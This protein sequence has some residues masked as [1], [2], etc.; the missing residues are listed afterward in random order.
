MVES[1]INKGTKFTIS[2]PT[3]LFASNVA[4]GDIEDYNI[5]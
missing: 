2:F 4:E 5:T 1:K 3:E